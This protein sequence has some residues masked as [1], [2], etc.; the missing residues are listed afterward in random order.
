MPL[1]LKPGGG[2]FEDL[3]AVIGAL[4]ARECHSERVHSLG[5]DLAGS[6]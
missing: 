2:E 1:A 6:A 4:I 5:C 3:T